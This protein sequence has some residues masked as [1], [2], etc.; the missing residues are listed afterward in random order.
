[1][2][3]LQTLNLNLEPNEA[4]GL[5][6]VRHFELLT[7]QGWDYGFWA[8]LDETDVA[9][10]IV[11]I[12]HQRDLGTEG[13]QIQRLQVDRVGSPKRADDAESSAFHDGWVYVFGSQHGGKEGPIRPRESWVARFRETDVDPRL[14]RPVILDVRRLELLLHEVVNDGL[15]TADVD[16][17]PM[18]PAGMRAFLEQTRARAE[19]KERDYGARV[20]HGD[21]TINVEGAAFLEDGTAL[22]GLRYPVAADG[23][24]LVVLVEGIQRLFD[25]V[26]GTAAPA[27]TGVWVVDAIGGGG[28]IAGVRDLAIVDGELHLVTGNIDSRNKGS[29]LLEDHPTGRHTIATHFRSALPGGKKF[30]QELDAE[31]VR[32]FPDMPRVEGI[33][34]DHEGDTSTT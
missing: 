14:E 17:L 12:G 22:L 26:T 13:F 16:L 25:D 2:S 21:W 15:K 30:T 28:Q 20:R 3:D 5:S 29:V 4:S 1:M 7:Q 19:D 23:R 18:G 8:I 27:V 31:L 9:D 34:V 10:G 33:A 32:E 11:L 24:P 6:E